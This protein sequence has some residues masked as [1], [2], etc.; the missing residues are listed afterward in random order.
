MQGTML[1]ESPQSFIIVIIIF[2][3]KLMNGI[4]EC[5]IYNEYFYGMIL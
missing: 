5:H 1:T 2:I 4:F 3:S